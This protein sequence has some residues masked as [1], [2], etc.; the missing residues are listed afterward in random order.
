MKVSLNHHVL[1]KYLYLL[2]PAVPKMRM[3]PDLTC[4]CC[5]LIC[6]S[7]TS[8][9]SFDVSVTV[10][11][12]G[13]CGCDCN[14]NM[15]EVVLS[16]LTLEPY[17]CLHGQ[18]AFGVLVRGNILNGAVGQLLKI[19]FSTHLYDSC[20][21]R[22]IWTIHWCLQKTYCCATTKKHWCNSDRCTQTWNCKLV[23]LFYTTFAAAIMEDFIFNTVDLFIRWHWAW[24][25]ME[26]PLIVLQ[27]SIHALFIDGF[28]Y[29]YMDSYGHTCMLW[30]STW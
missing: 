24:G 22:N 25:G 6:A 29:W 10:R 11:V 7:P 12:G 30:L 8:V 5:P 3:S 27:L 20:R 1:Y 21:I 2:R 17:N 9:P 13:L 23:G 15:K 26:A 16:K 4:F 14:T 28:C 19:Y 18:E